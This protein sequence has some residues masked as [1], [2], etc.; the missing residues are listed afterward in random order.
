MKTMTKF[1]I[2]TAVFVFSASQDLQAFIFESDYAKEVREI[3][4]L[5]SEQNWK[6][7]AI[8]SARLSLKVGQ[9]IKIN[10]VVVSNDLSLTGRRDVSILGNGEVY[11]TYDNPEG[12]RQFDDKL[13][14]KVSSLKNKVRKYIVKQEENLWQL[15]MSTLKALQLSLKLSQTERGEIAELISRAVKESKGILFY[16]ELDLKVCWKETHY[17]TV[18]KTREIKFTNIGVFGDR[19]NDSYFE[20]YMEEEESTN[21]TCDKTKGKFKVS[22]HDEQSARLYEADLLISS[23]EKQVSLTDV[24]K[25]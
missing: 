11:T 25:P 22:V 21:K 12:V 6:A 20:D 15:K 7:A 17:I 4:K 10:K 5:E 9:D 19:F 24:A 1:L 13:K 8:Y 2:I 3:A 18:I 23:Y 14:E 16:G